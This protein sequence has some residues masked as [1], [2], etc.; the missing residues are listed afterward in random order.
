[1]PSRLLVPAAVAGAALL[2]AAAVLGITLATRQ[3]P[4]QPHALAGKPGVPK[5]LDTP[6]AAR[7]RTAFRTWPRGSLKQMEELGRD[8]PRDPV[9]QLYRG[10]AL[11]YAGY[12]ADAVAALQKAK[13]LGR[14]TIHE[15]EADNILHPQYFPRYPVFVPT[16]RNALLERGSKLQAEGHQH[17]AERVYQ[18]AVR[19]DPSDD[20]AQ[21]A[22]AVARFDKDDLS[23]SF[24]RLGPL[25]RRFPRSQPVRYYLGLLLAWTGQGD[26]AIAQFRK[27]VALGR[28]TP[29]GKSA[30]TFLASLEKVRTRPPKR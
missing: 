17:S 11:A 18:R 28:T 10:V 24:S 20:Q 3:T 6:A 23:A 5:A 26:E 15:I 19:A 12:G 21:V 4:A 7:I 25:T 22:A 8:Y 14:D 16:G 13:R 29:L 30:S 27:T 2:A 1:M 9:V